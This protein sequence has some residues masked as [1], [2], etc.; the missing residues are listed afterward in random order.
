MYI[1]KWL[2]LRQREVQ[3]GG[4]MADSE[5]GPS[6][7]AVLYFSMSSMYLLRE[8]VARFNW[9][10][11]CEKDREIKMCTAYIIQRFL[12]WMFILKAIRTMNPTLRIYRLLNETWCVCKSWLSYPTSSTVVHATKQWWLENGLSSHICRTLSFVMY[13]ITLTKWPE[14][15]F[16]HEQSEKLPLCLRVMRSDNILT[17]HSDWLIVSTS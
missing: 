1:I 9:D 12:N 17:Y 2:A 16:Y 4:G 7:S 14:S 5:P 13:Y 11:T 3:H 6:N 8:F 10:H 15:W